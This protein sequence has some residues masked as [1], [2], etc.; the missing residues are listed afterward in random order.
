[1]RRK[2]KFGA[3]PLFKLGREIERARETEMERETEILKELYFEMLETE[4]AEGR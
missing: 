2:E 1:M 3:L 4:I